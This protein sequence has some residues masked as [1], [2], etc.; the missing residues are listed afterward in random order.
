MLSLLVFSKRHLRISEVKE[1]VAMLRTKA[2]MNLNVNRRPITKRI[3]EF[4]V[5]FVRMIDHDSRSEDESTIL[6]SHSAVRMFLLEG[7][8]G[9]EKLCDGKDFVTSDVVRE[10]CLRYLSQP[11]YSKLL[12][13]I[14]PDKFITDDSPTGNISTHYLLSYAAKYWHQHFD[15]AAKADSKQGAEVGV[16]PDPQ[17]FKAVQTFLRSSNFATCIQVQSLCVLG[18]FMQSYDTITDRLVKT[19]RVLPNW[20]FDT[21]IFHQYAHFTSEWGELL[22]CGISRKISGEMDRCLW[23][24]LGPGHFLSGAE[25]RYNCFVFKAALE[26]PKLARACQIQK[27]SPDGKR[28]IS[29]SICLDG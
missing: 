7:D 4:L 24:S 17:V 25:S 20:L 18:H 11:R 8:I 19:K 14:G 1:G 6:L 2:S 29:S 26:C 10:T 13:K 23:G 12:Q 3:Q 9:K 21:D 22:N 16:A 5:P 28:L 15:T 27:L